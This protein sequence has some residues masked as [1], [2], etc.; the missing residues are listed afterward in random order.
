VGESFGCELGVHFE[1]EAMGGL[2]E[3][4]DFHV[5]RHRMSTSPPEI[6]LVD[7]TFGD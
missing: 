7:V 5:R 3:V 2:L 1:I 6:R 4:F